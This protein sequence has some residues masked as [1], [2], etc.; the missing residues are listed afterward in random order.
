MRMLEPSLIVICLLAGATPGFADTPVVDCS[1]KSLADAVADATDKNPTVTFTGICNGPVVVAIDGL[2][3]KGVGTAII[4]GGDGGADALTVIGASRVS[5]VD[6]EVTHGLT[7]I[8]VRDGSHV[9]L[10]NVH[11]RRNALSGVVIRT[12]SSAVLTNVSVT[13]N[14]TTGVGVDDG[15]SVTF[16]NSTFTGNAARDLQLTFGSRA[17]LQNTL[18]GTVACDATVLVRGA[19]FTCPQ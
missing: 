16:K 10:T 15:V 19:A 13:D 1:K 3:L 14:G 8:V 7:G 4:D 6:F 9:T 2:T 12:A 11:S 5:L 18:I 17:T